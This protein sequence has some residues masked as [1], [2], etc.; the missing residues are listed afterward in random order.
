MDLTKRKILTIGI[1]TLVVFTILPIL[2]VKGSGPATYTGYVKDRNGRAIANAKVTLFNN[3]MQSCIDYTDSNGY[4]CVGDIAVY[5]AYIRVEKTTWVSVNQ[6]VS[7]IGGTYNFN[8]YTSACALIV[9]GSDEQHF[10]RDAYLMYNTLIDHYSYK[11]SRIYL[12]TRLSS[13]DGNTIPRDYATSQSNVETACEAI[14]SLVTSNDDVLVY[15]GSHGITHDPWIGA[16]YYTLDCGADEMK[17]SE[18]DN[19]LDD[20]SCNR[21]LVMI[22]SCHSGYFIGGGMDD[23][24]NRAILTSCKSTELSWYYGGDSGHSYWNYGLIRALDPDLNADDADCDPDNNRVSV[25]EFY[26]YAYDIVKDADPFQGTYYQNPQSWI[27]SSFGNDEYVYLGD[28][29]Y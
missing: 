24:S 12:I 8:L 23:E 11:A 7:R 14:D 15:W 29:Y 18:L 10:N 6:G 1:M 21:M 2:G 17:R 28:Q 20:I 4:Y 9:A 16:T 3:G 13:V 26:D 22:G 25:W 27:G 5:D 19:A